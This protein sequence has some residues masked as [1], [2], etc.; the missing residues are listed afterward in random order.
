MLFGHI[1]YV[2]LP[3]AEDVPKLNK[4]FDLS[5]GVSQQGANWSDL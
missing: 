5:V 3:R 4:I 2:F 1:S